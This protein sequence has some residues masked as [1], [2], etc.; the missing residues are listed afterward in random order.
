MSAS[1]ST[2]RRVLVAWLYLIAVVHLVGSV[3]FTWAGSSG[4]LDGYLM[5]VEHAFWSDTPPAAA[6][7]QQIWWTSLFG[8]TLQSYSLYMLALVHIGNRARR[9][10][11]WGWLI[12]GLM[13][14]APQDILLSVQA[15]VWT[16][17]WMDALALLVLIPPMVWLYGHDRSTSSIA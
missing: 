4:L 6:R 17:L 11:V 2:L 15:G 9:S 5:I 10:S 7:L 3:L 12:A 14:W 13:L 8:A 1:S 16:H